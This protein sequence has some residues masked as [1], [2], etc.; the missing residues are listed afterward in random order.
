M[1]VVFPLDLL[2]SLEKPELFPE[3]EDVEGLSEDLED[4]VEGLLEDFTWWLT[5]DLHSQ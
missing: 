2:K 3:E 5:S 4:V 1:L